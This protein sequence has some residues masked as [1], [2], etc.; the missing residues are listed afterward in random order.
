M[1]GK[2]IWCGKKGE[3]DMG[4]CLP[5]VKEAVQNYPLRRRYP[6]HRNRKRLKYATY[7]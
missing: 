3:L 1:T 7:D 2:C 4:V 5:C 6:N